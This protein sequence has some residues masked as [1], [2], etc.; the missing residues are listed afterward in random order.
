MTSLITAIQ[1]LVN[2][3][4]PLLQLILGAAIGVGIFK[5]VAIIA[6]RVETKIKNRDPGKNTAGN[7]KQRY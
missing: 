7:P 2:A 5:I 3:L 6:D 4:P 1:N